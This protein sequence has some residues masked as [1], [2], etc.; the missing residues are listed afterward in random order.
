VVDSFVVKEDELDVNLDLAFSV[1]FS[2]VDNRAA[3]SYDVLDL[4]LDFPLNEPLSCLN[5]KA[6]MVSVV[7]D[8]HGVA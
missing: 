3:I 4:F 7:I 5:A 6:S 2:T 1:Y 8:D